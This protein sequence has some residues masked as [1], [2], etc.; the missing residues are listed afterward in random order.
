MC[1]RA[2]SALII[3]AFLNCLFGC[4]HTVMIKPEEVREPYE[5]ILKIALLNGEIITF[6]AP[7]GE[8]SSSTN[9]ITGV[10]TVAEATP[11]GKKPAKITT[12]P[13]HVSADSVMSV[14]V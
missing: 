11:E 8:Y 4:T 5:N 6:A 1:K 3:T 9:K 2:I 12:R 13:Y 10:I 7:G 14:W